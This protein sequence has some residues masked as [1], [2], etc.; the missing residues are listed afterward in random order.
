MLSQ[1]LKNPPR[2]SKLYNHYNVRKPNELNQIDI[3]FLPDDKGYKYCLCV[4]DV[5]SRYKA[6]RALKLKDSESIIE[7]LF[8]IYENDEFIQKPTR[9]QCDKGREFTNL[10]FKNFCKR[11]KIEVIINEPSFH[12]SFVESFNRE[13]AKRLF[14]IQQA[15]ELKT[16]KINREWVKYLQTTIK[17]M[18]NTKTRLIKMTPIEAIKLETVEQPKNNFD[19]QDTKLHYNIGDKVR[20][21]LN[22]DE[23][24]DSENKKVKVERRRATDY[25][26]SIDE[27]KVTNVI[28]KPNSLYMHVIR[29][30]GALKDYPHQFTY[31]QLQKI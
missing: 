14:K 15:I 4:I 12:L 11:N 27:Y 25:K 18:N 6:A 3:L 31:W 7:A 30:I 17:D 26:Y 22:E 13:L 5:A 29:K 8:D 2:K 19:E 21:L 20:R 28:W 10:T 9:L 1:L 23:I 24:I 16:K